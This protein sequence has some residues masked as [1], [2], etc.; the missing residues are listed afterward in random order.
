M[1]QRLHRLFVLSARLEQKTG[2]DQL[3]ISA[4]RR[5]GHLLAYWRHRFARIEHMRHLAPSE[6]I[7]I[8]RPKPIP[9]AHFDT[10]GSAL[11]QC[12]QEFSL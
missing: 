9:I 8:I 4:A 7:E 5:R 11:R 1:T 6:A 2:G 12:S 10:V 3:G